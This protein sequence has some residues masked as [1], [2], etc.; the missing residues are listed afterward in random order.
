MRLAFL[1]T[2][3]SPYFAACL[4]E[5]QRRGVELMIYAKS[6]DPTAPFDKGQFQDLGPI[7]PRES[8]SSDSIFNKV[9]AFSP[10]CVYVGGWA[11]REYMSV[12]RRIRSKGALVVC[13]CDTQ[14]KG[15]FRQHLAGFTAGLHVKRAIDVMWVSGERQRVL[16]AALGY[17]GDRCWEGVYAC[18]WNIWSLRAGRILQSGLAPHFLFVGRYV[19]EKGIDTLVN[20]FKI[21]RDSIADPWDLVCVGKGPLASTIQRPGIDDRGFVQ[22][23]KLPALMS[24]AGGFILP[25]RF[26]PWGVVIQEAAAA[27]LPL[28][29]SDA[30]GA[31]VHLLK[32]SFNGFTFPAGSASALAERMVKMSSLRE[33]QRSEMGER[34]FQLSKQYTPERWADIL[35]SGVERSR[36][37]VAEE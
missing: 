37:A 12:C 6:T 28:L 7:L 8:A 5:I 2:R 33:D 32:D 10:H 27:G 24:C 23:E 9:N 4:R 35:L 30:C 14:W 13:G 3:L 17:S 19:Q 16:A 29:C 26:E 22:P 31:T 18:D 36:S 34:S 1:H 20:A 25:S 21:Y 15:S 11:D